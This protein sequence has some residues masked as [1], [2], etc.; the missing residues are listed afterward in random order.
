MA[1]L[2]TSVGAFSL[3]ASATR[4]SFVG[5]NPKRP[6]LELVSEKLELDCPGER[7]DCSLVLTLVVKNPSQAT[8]HLWILADWG[9]IFNENMVFVDG[10]LRGSILEEEPVSASLAPGATHT[11]TVKTGENLGWSD[12]RFDGIVD[13]EAVTP[14]AARHPILYAGFQDSVAM[15]LLE[16][17]FHEAFATLGSFAARLRVPKEWSSRIH[18]ERW[19]ALQATEHGEF[20][21]VRAEGRAS[22]DIVIEFGQ[23]REYPLDHGGPYIGLGGTFGEFATFVGRAGYEVAFSPE[24]WEIILSLAGDVHGNGSVSFAPAFEL[25]SNW[26]VVSSLSLGAGG[27]FLVAPTREAGVRVLGG[28][29]FPFLGVLVSADLWPARTEDARK[30][31]VALLLRA[32][33]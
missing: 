14:L 10:G 6:V 32:S 21:E 28:A 13:E 19:L 31:E 26:M 9:P 24:S 5:S 2:V 15:I 17:Q 4:L 12:R 7:S 25:A 3:D 23:S 29:Q 22:P 27:V 33:F 18:L 30:S 1:A 16:T 11:L 8:E 20:A